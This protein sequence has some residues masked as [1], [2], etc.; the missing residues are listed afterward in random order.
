MAKNL[1]HKYVGIATL[2]RILGVSIRMTEPGEFNDPFELLPEIIVR[3]NQVEEQVS[4]SFDILAPRRANP[5]EAAVQLKDGHVASDIT[6]RHILDQLNQQVGILCLS[7]SPDSI[8][9]WS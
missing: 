7:K 6:S 9:M 1:L 5:V 2:K 4:F 8:L 3:T